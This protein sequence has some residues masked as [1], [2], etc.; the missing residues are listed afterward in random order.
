MVPGHACALR[1]DKSYCLLRYNLHKIHFFKVH[2]SVLFRTFTRLCSCHHRLILEH[3]YH[4]QKKPCSALSSD[5]PLPPAPQPLT[6]PVLLSVDLPVPDISCGWNPTLCMWFS[7]FGLF[8]SAPRSI[9]MPCIRSSFLF[10]WF[11]IFF[12]FIFGCAGSSLL[13]GLSY[14]CGEQRLLLAVLHGFLIGMASLVAE[15]GL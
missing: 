3:F 8:H 5:S 10:F 9:H 1:E 11:K 14:S 7:G 15:H 4:S 2:N 12:N 6:S 13:R